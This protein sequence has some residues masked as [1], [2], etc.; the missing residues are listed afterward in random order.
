MRRFTT[1]EELRLARLPPTVNAALKKALINEVAL[2]GR[3]YDPDDTGSVWLIESNDSDSSV[4]ERLGAPF[5][6]L[7]FEKVYH[8]PDQGL[9]IAYLVRNNSR[10]DTLII[11]DTDWL[12]E[13]W[14]VFLISQT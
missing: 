8:H 2:G 11:P 4:I 14:A 10:C 9:F 6:K 5:T 12:S 1:L 3:D 7:L 13:A